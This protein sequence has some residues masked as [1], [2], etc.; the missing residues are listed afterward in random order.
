MPFKTITARFAGTRC[1]RCDTLILVGQKFRYGGRGNCWHLSKECPVK[2]GPVTTVP[3]DGQEDRIG[4]YPLNA[5]PLVTA[6]PESIAFA[7]AFVCGDP[8]D[9]N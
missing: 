1:R 7:D 4:R 3:Q 9:C 2:S 8:S 6:T 5:E